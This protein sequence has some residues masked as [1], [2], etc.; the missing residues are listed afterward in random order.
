MMAR[1]L[2][3]SNSKREM[4]RHFKAE[5]IEQPST[6]TTAAQTVVI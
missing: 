1:T 2:L 6:G 3:S 5:N 4:Y